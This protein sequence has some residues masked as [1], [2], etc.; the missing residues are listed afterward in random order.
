MALG[1]VKPEG[2]KKALMGQRLWA[3]VTMYLEDSDVVR[4]PRGAARNFL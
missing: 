3:I 1:A 4:L 2:Q